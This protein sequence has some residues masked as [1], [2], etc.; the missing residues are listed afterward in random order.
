MK[1]L[2]LCLLG[3]IGVAPAR[4][5]NAN[6][7]T[8]T[9]YSPQSNSVELYLQIDGRSVNYVRNPVDS[10]QISAAV[11]VTIT[12]TKGEE[13]VLLDRYVLNSPVGERPESFVD[14][15]R[16]ALGNGRYT[17]TVDLADAKM[18]DNRTQLTRE[19]VLDY[20]AD[21]VSQSDIQLLSRQRAATDRDPASY[22]KQGRF[23]EGSATAFLDRQADKL[24]FYNEVYHADRATDSLLLITYYL[25]DRSRKEQPRR[26]REKTRK[27]R[28][29]ALVT[30]LYGMDL[31]EVPSGNYQLVVEVRAPAGELLSRQ[32]M[33]VQRSN[34]RYDQ[35]LAPADTVATEAGFTVGIDSSELR[36]SLLALVPLLSEAE[37][38]FINALIG[39]R[40]V[41]AQRRYLEGFWTRE[42]PADPRGG[43]EQFLRVARSV[44]ATYNNGFGYG[45][46]TDRGYLFIRHGKPDDMIRV[47]ND[48]NAPPYE[49]WVYYDF[50][51]TR[52]SNVKFV[53]F[54]P[55]LAKNGFTMLHSTAR[56]Y[57]NN[58]QWEIQLYS[59]APD[60]IQGTNY[61]DATR[62]QDKML[63]RAREN[64]ENL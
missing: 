59:Q 39:N 57:V 21:K 34:P 9:F 4:A 7:A 32:E 64:W 6:L 35:L 40:N 20:P 23:L 14:Q 11:E 43:Y 8:A 2:L 63:R 27:K 1:Y 61:L 45:F 38:G 36:F 22:R 62:M 17:L 12:V 15:K 25:E 56:G 13:L 47:E 52:Q 55:S 28:P 31:R 53:F 41:P 60:E 51:Q 42:N 30:L 49:M 5:L 33:D 44:D 46:Q 19:V 58:P 50:P 10:T 48:P 18:A 26:Y 37:G 54:N 29:R 16:Y 24:L 3:L